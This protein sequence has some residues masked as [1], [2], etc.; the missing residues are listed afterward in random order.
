MTGGLVASRRVPRGTSCHLRPQPSGISSHE[1][2]VVTE[3]VIRKRSRLK[4]WRQTLRSLSGLVTVQ[5][6]RPMSGLMLWLAVASVL[7]GIF[8]IKYYFYLQ[9]RSTRLARRPIGTFSLCTARATHLGPSSSAPFHQIGKRAI[10]VL[11]CTTLR[12]DLSGK[13]DSTGGS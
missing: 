2:P 12:Y 9:V 4:R 8:D 13:F 5:A 6:Y 7:S 11:T 1:R 10:K 3:D